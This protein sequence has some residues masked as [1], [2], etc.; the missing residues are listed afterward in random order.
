MNSNSYTK[1]CKFCGAQIPADA[2]VC[3]SCGR[4]VEIL[5]TASQP[6]I[7]NNNITGARLCNKWV[8]FVLCFL[9]GFLGAHR[10]YEGKIGTGILYLFTCGLFGIGWLVDLIIII[11][12]PINYPSYR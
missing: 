4:Q 2:V 10:F 9:F 6:V 5:K 12:R 8:A 3:T 1:Y 7:V 11:F